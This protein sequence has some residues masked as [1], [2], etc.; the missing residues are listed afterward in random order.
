MSQQLY[1]FVSSVLNV[2]ITIEVEDD[3]VLQVVFKTQ[4]S[5]SSS[6]DGIDIIKENLHQTINYIDEHIVENRSRIREAR[7]ITRCDPAGRG[8]TRTRI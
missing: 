3:E 1:V 2:S 6:L 8:N 7:K 4:F 5:K